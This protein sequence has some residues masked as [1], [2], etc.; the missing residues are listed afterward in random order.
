MWVALIRLR[1]QKEQLVNAIIRI[2]K[3]LGGLETKTAINFLVEDNYK[4]CFRILLKYYDKWYEKGLHAKE[5]GEVIKI[6][7]ESVN[8]EGNAKKIIERVW[9]K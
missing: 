7:G 3:R 8:I 6:E 9:K 4:E 5:K 2:Q 1:P